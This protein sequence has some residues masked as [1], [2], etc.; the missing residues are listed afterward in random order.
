MERRAF[1]QASAVSALAAA[2]AA[3]AADPERKPRE[4]YEL[5]VCTLKPAKLPLLDQ[6]LG[7]AFIPTLKRY[8][9][10]PVGVFVDKADPEQNKVYVLI[11]YPSADQCAGLSERLAD[12]A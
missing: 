5:R 6:Y 3:T 7:K 10:G 12:D 2:S 4:H 9:L 8:G 1:M 11:V